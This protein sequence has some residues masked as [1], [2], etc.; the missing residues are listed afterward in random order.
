MVPQL[1]SLNRTELHERLISTEI[2]L[3]TKSFSLTS[4]KDLISNL[5]VQ[6]KEKNYSLQN[7]EFWRVATAE[8]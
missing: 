6:I 7:E 2:N 1:S 5:Q 4:M 8:R 3:R